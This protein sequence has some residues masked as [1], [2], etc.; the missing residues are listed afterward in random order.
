MVRPVSTTSTAAQRRRAF[1][2]GAVLALA[3]PWHLRAQEA[4]AQPPT[5]PAQPA[6]TA[7]D[8]PTPGTA[9]H[10]QATE[11]PSTAQPIVP[12]QTTEQP[13]TKTASPAANPAD[14][15]ARPVFFATPPVIDGKLDEPIWKT[16]ARL[17][18]FTQIEP[19][20]GEPATE[21]TDVYL[22]YDNDNLYIGAR[23]HDAEPKKI[24][25]TTLTRDSD[26]GY[27]DT[28]QILIDTYHDGR[29]GYVFTT[30]SGGVQV[31][32]LVRNEGEQVDLDWDGIWSVQGHRDS[33]GWT[34]E[35]AIPWR[36]L[37]FPAKPEQLWGFNVEREVA[38]KQERSFWK[39]VG[40]SWYARYKL[41]EAGTIVGLEGAKPGGR[42]H[43]A[44]YAILGAQKP[45]NGSTSSI[46][47]AGGDIKINL[48]S[49][50]VADLTVKTDF[51]ETEADEQDVNLSRNA[52]LFPEKRAFFL[53]GA[54]TFYVGERPDPEHPA[55]TFLFFSRQIG[56]TPD[57]RASIPILGG[58]KL[59][60]HEG[61]YDVGVLSLQTEEVKNRPDGYGGLINEPQTTW[62]VLRLKRDLGNGSTFGIIGLSKDA[63]G[64]QNRV[65]AADWDITLNP[66]LRTGGYA[67]KSSTPGVSGRDYAASGDLYW[68]SR[69]ARLHSTYT[70]IGQN[71]NDEL[72]FL[73]RVGIR[74]FRTDN[75]WILWPDH[76]FKQAWFV[77]DLDYITD[78]NTGQLQTRIN[79]GKFSA[80]F[81]DSSGI[82]YKYYDELEV[83]TQPLEIKKGLFIP[84]GSYRFGHS[85][86]GY[87]SDYTKP[88]GWA[89][90][91]AWGDYYDGHI[92]QS[93]LFL[94]YRPIPGLFTAVTYQET[95]VHLKEGDFTSD[96]ALAEVTYAFSN[97]LSTRFWVQWDKDANL[98]QK[99][100]IDW[101]FRPGSKLFIVY[102]N[103][104]SYVDF[105]DPRQPLFGTPGKSLLAKV[106]FLY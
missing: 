90:R 98:R 85:F 63:A 88:F 79:H 80:Y 105:F 6:P 2:L 47:Q 41:S 7:P 70:Q 52:L 101:E 38:H 4:P 37:R 61:K 76:V 31:D 36:T 69:S 83:L 60:G 89:G 92:L 74:D 65:G 22:G 17:G 33:E 10:P 40:H 19:H 43:I 11:P 32:G 67:A 12:P 49:D 35:I 53:E 75:Y 58:V 5:P 84:S 55:E 50:L 39:P 46:T 56:L 42:F 106:V 57:G 51:S 25:T 21:Q 30:N 71:F 13:A 29:S 48:A 24:V 78:L 77:Y 14:Y 18:K 103:I 102:Q 28:L 95:K 72:G 16:G 97:R 1:L 44:P 66:S 93:F 68:D 94:T 59:T 20:E 8:V 87:Q 54:S 86:L 100:D 27:D 9:Q 34:V 96:I 82:A 99:F 62:S 15:V 91:L 64:D 73:T 23:C 81:R 45:Q 26:M 3:L 104:K